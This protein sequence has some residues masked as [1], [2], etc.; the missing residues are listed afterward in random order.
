MKVFF[1]DKRQFAL[2]GILAPAVKIIILSNLLHESNP[3]QKEF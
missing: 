2:R 3:R 1:L